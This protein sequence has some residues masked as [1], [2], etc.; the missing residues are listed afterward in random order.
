MIDLN[1]EK[2]ALDNII[3]NE[4]KEKTQTLKEII[5]V[6]AK[7]LVEYRKDFAKP[8]SEVIRKVDSKW[9][10]QSRKGK[11]LGTSDTKAGAVKRLAQVEYFKSH[12]KNEWMMTP[13]SKQMTESSH[14]DEG[15]FSD[16]TLSIGD[17]IYDLKY[18]VDYSVSGDYSRATFDSPEEYPDVDFNKL[19][20]YDIVVYDVG[21][22]APGR[23]A[24]W[25]ELPKEI[26]AEL[27]KQILDKWENDFEMPEPD[28]D[29]PDYDDDYYGEG[30][31]KEYTEQNFN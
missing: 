15:E 9:Q 1:K 21:S 31:E 27:E 25:E 14:T 3:K 24:K 6:D 11:N 16:G 10:V 29:E 17:K 12:P 28:H 20:V 2:E 26:Q 4:W 30:K 13:E 22:D 8:I 18:E 19:T 7:D 23:P 5:D